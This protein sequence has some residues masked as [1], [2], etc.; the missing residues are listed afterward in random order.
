ME[1]SPVLNLTFPL[2]L[3]SPGTGFPDGVSLDDATHFVP[4][5][6]PSTLSSR[7]QYTAMDNVPYSVCD[8]TPSNNIVVHDELFQ[9]SVSTTLSHAPSNQSTSS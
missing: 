2:L 4:S 8:S 5:V 6:V 7:I 9:G 3:D 1:P